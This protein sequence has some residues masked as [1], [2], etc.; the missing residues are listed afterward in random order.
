MQNF[1]TGKLISAVIPNGK[2]K[3]YQ[4]FNLRQLISLSKQDC[5]ISGIDLE[6]QL[7]DAASQ[8]E[9]LSGGY[10]L[11]YMIAASFLLILA[12]ALLLVVRLK[13]AYD[14][15]HNTI[16][17]SE[18]AFVIFYIALQSSSSFI[19]EEHEFWF[20]ALTSLI[21]VKTLF[22]G[23]GKNLPSALAALIF[24]RLPHNWNAVGYQAL[25]VKD[26]KIWLLPKSPITNVVIGMSL[27]F[28]FWNWNRSLIP[29]ERKNVS[30]FTYALAAS[31]LFAFKSGYLEDHQLLARMAYATIIV[32]FTTSHSIGSVHAVF[33][34][35][36]VFL[37]KPHN[38]LIL[39]VIFA[40]SKLLV[41]IDDTTILTNA[42]RVALVHF[43][44]F[45]LG[46]SNLIVSL[47]FSNAYIGF[48]SFNFPLIS[49]IT[50]LIT[51]S[52][53]ILASFFIFT[54]VRKCKDRSEHFMI[55]DLAIW[56]I[57]VTTSLLIS[58]IFQRHHLFVWS[59]FAHRLLF[60]FGWFLFYGLIFVIIS[61]IN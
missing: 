41:H 5:E 7:L 23:A 56:K 9:N 22:L 50:F 38:A 13:F 6:K 16:C 8:V 42:L 57:I 44:Y 54:Q 21:A 49:L 25:Q 45:A 24:S 47:D 28:G 27:M 60:E 55:L 48:S 19:E 39:T 61:S 18:L 35:L 4:R 26:S 10:N 11:G 2:L 20:F 29:S 51:W 32:A 1:N 14:N 31:V 37:L 12:L 46:P 52:G 15:Q 43:S 58:L 59:V 3:S 17:I 33:Y 36:S 40:L 34:R 30:R 53:P